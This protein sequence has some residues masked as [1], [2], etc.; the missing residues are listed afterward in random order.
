LF[1]NFK[2][3]FSKTLIGA[4]QFIGNFKGKIKKSMA[5]CDMT[6]TWAVS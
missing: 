5:V 3:A 2:G 1:F 6:Y 4:D